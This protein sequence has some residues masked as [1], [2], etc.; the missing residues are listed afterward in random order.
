MDGFAGIEWEIGTQGFVMVK[1]V[2]DGVTVKGKESEAWPE[3]H[4][5]S[6]FQLGLEFFR[7]GFHIGSIA[8]GWGFVKLVIPSG[9]LVSHG[10]M[11]FIGV[12]TAF[13]ESVVIS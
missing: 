4:G 5:E 3:G 12:K 6:W 1:D 8:L 13:L 11:G 9:G 2:P 7:D 10:A